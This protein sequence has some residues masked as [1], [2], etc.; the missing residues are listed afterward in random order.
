MNE[1]IPVITNAA[2]TILAALISLL[3]VLST[4]WI[5][6]LTAKAKVE[7]AKI[8]DDHFRAL[9]DESIARVD[10]LAT[11][12][13][14]QIEQT[15][16]KALREAVKDGK[17]DKKELEE[18]GIAARD[19]IIDSLSEEYKKAL[20][21]AVGSVE[22]YVTKAVETKV[23]ELKNGIFTVASLETA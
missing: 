14:T 21:F 1:V 4:R 2:A 10:D 19:E 13:V 8:E 22:G 15:T 12:T 5:N 11:K 20:M 9:V 3:A 18:L 7:N 6:T 17:A 16:A 23:Y